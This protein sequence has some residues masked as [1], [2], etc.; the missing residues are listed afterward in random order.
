[1]PKT[2]MARI[3]LWR[4]GGGTLAAEAALLLGAMAECLDLGDDQYTRGRPHPMIEPELRNEHIAAAL[5][6]A[7]VA[8][9]LFDVVPHKKPACLEEI[10][11]PRVEC[12]AHSSSPV[13]NRQRKIH[14]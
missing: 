5:A 9:L 2:W 3:R 8:V 7:S 11:A 12:G 10:A 14:P 1:M 4:S 6:D 13:R